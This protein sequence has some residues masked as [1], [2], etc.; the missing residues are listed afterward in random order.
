MTENKLLNETCTISSDVLFFNLNVLGNVTYDT[1]LV[2]KRPL[3]IGD[4]L[5]RT[6]KEVEITGTKTF[7]RNVGMKSN[8][9]IMSGMVNGHLLDEFVTIDTD[10]VFPSKASISYFYGPFLSKF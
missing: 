3:N 7:L 10:Q 1:L 2:N 9:T 4:L 8:V 5:L 6:D